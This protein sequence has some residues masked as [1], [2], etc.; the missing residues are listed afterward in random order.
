MQLIPSPA[1]QRAACLLRKAGFETVF[2]G[3]CVRDA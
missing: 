1:A 3:G 2:V